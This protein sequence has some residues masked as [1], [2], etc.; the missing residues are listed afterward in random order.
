MVLIYCVLYA[1]LGSKRAVER[2]FDDIVR[3]LWVVG[4]IAVVVSKIHFYFFTNIL[5]L[6][7]DNFYPGCF[8]KILRQ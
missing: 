8:V 6:N 3:L 1:I 4:G 7:Q 2:C 5:C